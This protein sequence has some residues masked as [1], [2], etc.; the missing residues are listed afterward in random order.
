MQNKIFLDNYIKINDYVELYIPTVRE[1]Y[2]NE[3]DYYLLSYHLTAMPFTR[4]AELWLNKIDYIT[5]NFY[6]LFTYALYEMKVLASND[7]QMITKMFGT[8]KKSNPNIG[9]L[10]FRGFDIK[11][12]EIRYTED[13][14]YLVADSTNQHILFNETDIDKTAEV[15]RKI[16]GE[17]KD[18]RKEDVKGASGRY[19]LERAVK[20]L[21]RKLKKEAECPRQ[22]SII[23]SYIVT[24][25]NNKDFKYNFET[26]MDISYVEFILSVKQILQNIHVA[27]IDLGVYTGNIL[28]DKL[29]DKDRSYF[30]LEVI[31]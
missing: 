15:L 26:V 13:K 27:N 19:V 8:H 11:N 9:N 12:I 18:N 2:K 22:Y 17:K 28:A 24:L 29:T 23:E 7:T 31:K 6:D 14:H 3:D 20:V 30:A 16:I 25:V 10:F 5:L 21:K 4:R 1:V